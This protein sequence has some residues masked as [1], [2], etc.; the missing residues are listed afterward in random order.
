MHNNKQKELKILSF[1]LAII[2]IF[3]LLPLNVYADSLLDSINSLSFYNFH[4]LSPLLRIN[5][6]Y[7]KKYKCTEFYM[8]KTQ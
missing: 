6:K 5:K 7:I 4:Y 2:L 8:L 1:I 3:S